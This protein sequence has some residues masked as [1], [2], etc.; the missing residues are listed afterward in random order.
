MDGRWK[1]S[2]EGKTLPGVE[3]PPPSGLKVGSEHKDVSEQTESSASIVLM[4]TRLEQPLH[5]EPSLYI[6]GMLFWLKDLIHD[7]E[8]S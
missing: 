7:N 2:D 5:F 6:C 4:L 8:T 3:E 1:T